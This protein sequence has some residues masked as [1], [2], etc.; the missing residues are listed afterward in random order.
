MHSVKSRFVIGPSNI[1]FAG[2]YIYMCTF[3]PGNRTGWGSEGVNNHIVAVQQCG[4]RRGEPACLCEYL[5]GTPPSED[6]NV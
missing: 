4:W 1:L 3:Q 2:V 5:K 6:L